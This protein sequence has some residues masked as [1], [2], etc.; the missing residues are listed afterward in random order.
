MTARLAGMPATLSI[1]AMR[2]TFRIISVEVL[3]SSQP[4]NQIEDKMAKV[5]HEQAEAIESESEIYTAA[6]PFRV[7]P[8]SCENLKWPTS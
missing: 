2:H 3:F 7:I 6:S 4:T 8:K 1:S 5:C